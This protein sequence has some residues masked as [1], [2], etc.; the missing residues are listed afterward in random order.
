MTCAMTEENTNYLT[1]ILIYSSDQ[2]SHLEVVM[3]EQ[4][5]RFGTVT[6]SQTSVIQPE[7]TKRLGIETV[8]DLIQQMSY[9]SFG[10][11]TQHVIVLNIDTATLEAQNALLKLLEEPPVRTQIWLTAIHPSTVLP[12]ITSRCEELFSN[13]SDSKESTEIPDSVISLSALSHRELSELAE[14]Y[15]D[16]E[17]ALKFINSLIKAT[18]QQMQKNSSL[19]E[20]LPVI[21]QTVHYL[22]ANVNTRLALEHCFFSLK[23]IVKK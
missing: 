15:S 4:E 5:R 21:L 11:K 6:P 1:P 17:D 16:R 22:N 19:H 14:K 3:S 8:R 2:A 12:T 18:H 23:K 13:Y 9:G 20:T 7:S 10:G